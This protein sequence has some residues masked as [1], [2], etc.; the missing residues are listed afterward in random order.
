MKLLAELCDERNNETESKAQ[1]FFPLPFLADLILNKCN[2]CLYIKRYLVYFFFH[3]YLETEKNMSKEIM[4]QK[5][6]LITDIIQDIKTIGEQEEEKF[7]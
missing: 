3:V 7:G 6:L 5:S 4:N 1:I 2:D